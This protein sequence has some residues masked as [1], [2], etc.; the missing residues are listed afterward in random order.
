MGRAV[1]G[2]VVICAALC[3]AVTASSS[4]HAANVPVLEGTWDINTLI[5]GRELT[6]LSAFT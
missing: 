4:T 6:G 3:V 2:V 1:P 5:V